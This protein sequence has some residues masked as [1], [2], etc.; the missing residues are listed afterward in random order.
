MSSFFKS[1]KKPKIVDVQFLN[2]Y[3]DENCTDFS[4][5][6]FELP[7]ELAVEM[8]E[9]YH[10]PKYRKV[11]DS[12]GNEEIL[13]LDYRSICIVYSLSSFNDNWL[14][15]GDYIG[16]DYRIAKNYNGVEN[17]SLEWSYVYLDE[18]MD[19][20]VWEGY[21]GDK[22][23]DNF[24]I[25]YEYDYDQPHHTC[26]EITREDKEK[27]LDTLHEIIVGVIDGNPKRKKS[28]YFFNG[29]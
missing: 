23:I 5:W 28:L 10:I 7:T 24:D 21:V 14:H 22:Y 1:N 19:F 26:I 9:K 6:F 13:F 3:V 25:G 12:N 17:V 18:N 4:E 15:K 8:K 16:D 29:D 11:I 20:V 27:L 2:G